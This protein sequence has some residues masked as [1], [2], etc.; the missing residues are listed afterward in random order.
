MKRIPRDPIRFD[1]LDLFAF[2]GLE[3]QI[4]LRSAE[5]ADGFIFRMRTSIKGSLENE[6]LLYGLRAERMFEALVVSLGRVSLIKQE[7]AGEIFASDDSLKVP[8]FRVIIPDGSQLLVEVKNYYQP[9]EALK[10][11][12]IGED[13]LRSLLQYSELMRCNLKLAIYWARWNIWTLVSPATFPKEGGRTVL[14]FE[15]AMFANEMA[16]LGDM[17]VGTRFPLRLRMVADRTKP[18]SIDPENLARFTIGS[19][20]LYC[21]GQQILEP[22]E[23]RIATYL[24]FYGKWY[25]EGPFAEIVQGELEAIEHRWNPGEDHGQGFEIAGS[26]SSMFSSMYIQATMDEELVGQVRMSFT[27][28]LL[29]RLIPEGYKGKALPLWMFIQKPSK[30]EGEGKKG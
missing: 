2:H 9:G 29:G 22:L 11:F 30:R 24:M 18:R 27:P 21:G 10:P 26:L 25:Y 7:D 4:S 20:E 5:A 13:Y 1:A 28:D 23:R 12:H 6:A 16:T 8:D 17:G 3:E 15:D 19:V 14:A